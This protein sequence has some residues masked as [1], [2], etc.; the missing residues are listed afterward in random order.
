MVLKIANS[1]S[2]HLGGS[3]LRQ[4]SEVFQGNMALIGR[5]VGVLGLLLPIF[6]V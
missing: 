4:N 3:N 2:R 5:E 6:R 1:A